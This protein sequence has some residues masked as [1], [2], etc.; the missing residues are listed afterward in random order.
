MVRVL[1]D[2]DAERLKVFDKASE[3]YDMVKS[4]TDGQRV[5]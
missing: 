3:T 2:I 4:H 1:N 5:S